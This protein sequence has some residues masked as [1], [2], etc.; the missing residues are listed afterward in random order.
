MSEHPTLYVFHYGVFMRDCARHGE[1]RNFVKS[2]SRARMPGKLYQLPTGL[3]IVLEGEG[4]VWGE[5]MTF[6]KNLDEAL[7]VMDSHEGFD[8]GDPE[9]S[10]QLRVVREVEIPSTGE[11]VQAYTW[12]FPPEKFNEREMHAVFAHGGDWRKFVMMPRYDGYAH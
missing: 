2:W 10:H 5:V 1:I 3:P 4:T 11:K 9:G 6:G 12:I 8:P 7:E